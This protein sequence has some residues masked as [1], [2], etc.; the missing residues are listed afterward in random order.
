MAT[1]QLRRDRHRRRA[2]RLRRR[3]PPRRSSSRRSLRREGVRRRRVPQLGLHSVEGAHRGAAP[4]RED[5]AWRARSGIT[6]ER[7]Q[8]RRRRRCRSGRTASSRSSPAASARS[9]RA[10]AA[11]VIMGEATLTAPRHGRG[12]DERRQERDA[13]RRRR[14]SSSRPA[15]TSIRI[16]GVR[17]RRQDRAHGA[18]GGEPRRGSRSAWCSSA[19]A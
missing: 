15:P 16:P 18:G 12:R 6:V 7:R 11:S 1:E 9:S 2:R 14:P 3:D 13:R 5:A 4:R 8:R 10:T 19:A 17:V